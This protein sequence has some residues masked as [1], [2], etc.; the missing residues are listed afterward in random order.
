MT[1]SP[2]LTGGAGSILRT[3]WRPF[4]SNNRAPIYCVHRGFYGICGIMDSYIGRLGDQG[5][6]RAWGPMQRRGESLD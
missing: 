1:T 5:N 2:L 6:L 3:A 4:I